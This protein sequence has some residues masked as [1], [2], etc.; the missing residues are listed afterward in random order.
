MAN[1]K[2]NGKLNPNTPEPQSV[3]NND[4][5]KRNFPCKNSLPT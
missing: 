5:P 4:N 1:S 2:N 3:K